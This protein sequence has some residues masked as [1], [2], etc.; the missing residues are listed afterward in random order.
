MLLPHGFEGQGPEHSSARIERFLTACAEDNIQVAYPTMPH[1]YFHLLRRQMYM[2]ERKPLIVFT[3]KSLLRHPAAR[4]TR[5]RACDRLVRRGARRSGASVASDVRRVMLCTGK[6][7]DRPRGAPSRAWT[8]ERRHPSSRAALSVPARRC[9]RR[10]RSAIRGPRSYWV[11]EE[12]E[13]MGAWS[14]VFTQLQQHG[15]DDRAR[16]ASGERFAGDGQQGDPRPGA[17]RDPRGS[18]RRTQLT[19]GASSVTSRSRCV[20]G[21]ITDQPDVDAS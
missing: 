13:N 3:P 12:P 16:V 14:F 5:E 7:A 6:V 9:R 19:C 11:Q 18:V 10:A 1:Q 21:D 4:S 20:R 2:R 17:G 15:C 8:D